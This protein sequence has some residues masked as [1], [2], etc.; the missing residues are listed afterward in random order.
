MLPVSAADQFTALLIGFSIFGCVLLWCAYAFFIRQMRKSA[1]TIAWCALLL[2]A[3]AALQ[4]GHFG[5]LTRGW[6][7]LGH[8]GYGMLLLLVPAAFFLFSSGALMPDRR[9]RVPSAVH[10]I[11]VVVGSFM[12][13]TWMAPI[14]FSIGTG[15]SLWFTHLI[16]SLRSDRPRFEFE[17]FFFGVFALMAIVILMLGVSTPYIDHRIFYLI[18]ANATGGALLLVIAGLIAFPEL[19]SDLSDAAEAAYATSTLTGVDKAAALRKLEHCMTNDRLWEDE[20]LNLSSLAEAC[21]LSAHQLS[22]LINTSF[23]MGFSRYVRRQRIAHAKR[24]L[25]D[26]H[27]ASVLSV[28]MATGFRSQ[29]AFYAAFREETGQAPGQF[30]KAQAQN[31]AHD[32]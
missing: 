12:P 20:S 23:N 2:G 9:Y 13:V 10:L 11:P 29:S 8:R 30:R 17:M 22:E 14:A 19:L 28:G 7:L 6:D 5:F 18:Y 4:I 26:D 1:S 24:L 16:Y 27:Q 3:L 31:P 25:L 32:A 15:Y 21:D